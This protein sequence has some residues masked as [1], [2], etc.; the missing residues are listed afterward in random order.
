MKTA[1]L[2]CPCCKQEVETGEHTDAY[3]IAAIMLGILYQETVR[4][5]KTEKAEPAVSEQIRRN[6]DTFCMHLN[7]F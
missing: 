7:R 4:L 6:V 3:T 5:S 1:T 2:T